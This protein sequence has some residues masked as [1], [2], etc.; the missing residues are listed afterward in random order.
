MVSGRIVV[1][2]AFS[3]YP[4]A[5]IKRVSTSLYF[6]LEKEKVSLGSKAAKVRLFIKKSSK[7]GVA[8]T[9]NMAYGDNLSVS[10]DCKKV[11]PKPKQ[12]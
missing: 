7:N 2:T 8:D 1:R 9:G 10:F 11:L 12:Y 5:E 4:I 6:S 3:E